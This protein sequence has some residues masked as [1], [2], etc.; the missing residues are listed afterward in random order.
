MDP[1]SVHNTGKTVF[2]GASHM[3]RVVQELGAA[4][5]TVVNICPAG[6]SPTKES[7]LAAAERVS[8]L[9][10]SANDT[11]VLDVWSN[12][13]FLGTDDMGFP[14]IPEKSPLD[15]RFHVV[16]SLQAAPTAVFEKLL[17]DTVPILDAANNAN[18]VL[19]VPFPRYV[20]EK[21]CSDS[22]HL[23]N[24]GT[25]SFW[26]ELERPE[27]AVKL[28]IASLS[29]ERQLKTFRIQDVV[30]DTDLSEIT[31]MGPNACPRIWASG[32]PVHF[33]PAVYLA[34]GKA[35]VNCHGNEQSAPKRARLESVVAH[36]GLQIK[37]GGA[38]VRLPDWLSGRSGPGPARGRGGGRGYGNRVW[39]SARGGWRRPRRF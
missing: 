15:G 28:A 33:T 25:D 30:G 29:Y 7:L 22:S 20:V 18:L 16:G 21:C 17:Q 19:V 9:N 5:G 2:L 34:I 11:L 4:S 37:R 32:D 36:S 23:T 39:R 8:E 38:Q 24:Y 27:T 31:E 26:M 3:R 1:D 35:L 14:K 12:S 13:A 10:L 6:W